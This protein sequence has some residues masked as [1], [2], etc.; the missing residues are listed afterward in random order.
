ML[1]IIN[2]CFHDR[3]IFVGQVDNKEINYYLNNSFLA[4]FPSL[5]DNFPYVI[6]EAMTTGKYVVCS[7]NIGIKDIYSKNKY[8]FATGNYLD[9]ANKVINV[10]NLIFKLIKTKQNTKD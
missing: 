10:F 3:I 1:S 4:V 8:L 7:D 2:K 5:F 9:L 6:L